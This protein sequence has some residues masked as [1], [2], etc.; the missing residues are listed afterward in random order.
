MLLEET[1]QIIPSFMF[2]K[3]NTMEIVAEYQGKP[4]LD[5]YSKILF[6]AGM[7]YG[8]LFNGC[9]EQRNWYINS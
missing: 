6:D 7:E 4:T 5:M 1:A 9:R 8:G 2:L 3:L